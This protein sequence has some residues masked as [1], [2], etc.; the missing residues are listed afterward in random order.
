MQELIDYA[1]SNEYVRQWAEANNLIP[2]DTLR[3]IQTV[4]EGK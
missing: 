1:N 2:K 3:Y 4:V